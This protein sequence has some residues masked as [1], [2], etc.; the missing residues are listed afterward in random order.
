MPLHELAPYQG[1]VP[2]LAVVLQ[3][4]QSEAVAA[5]CLGWKSRPN[6]SFNPKCP[7]A[8]AGSDPAT[9][10]PHTNEEP[11]TTALSTNQDYNGNRDPE[12]TILYG[13]SRLFE[14]QQAGQRGISELR[15]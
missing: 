13:K 1:V 4:H 7:S 9:Q 8:G 15:V 14:I 5:A 10:T 12:T 2:V 6:G 3:K 11:Y